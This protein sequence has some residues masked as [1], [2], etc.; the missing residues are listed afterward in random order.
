MQQVLWELIYYSDGTME[1]KELLKKY[2]ILSTFL[3]D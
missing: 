1:V 2:P 3:Y